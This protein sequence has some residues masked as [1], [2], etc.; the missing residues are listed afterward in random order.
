MSTIDKWVN[1]IEKELNLFT[2]EVGEKVSRVA[3]EVAKEGIEMLK[4][5]GDY[6]DRTGKYRKSFKYRIEK[7]NLGTSVKI[8]STQPQ[9]T[10][11]LEHGHAII[12]TS[13]QKYG[14]TWR[15]AISKSGAT[16]H[17]ARKGGT[18][19]TQAFPHWGPTEEFINKEFE[20]RIVQVLEE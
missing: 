9:L 17:H 12:N 8:Y 3:E 15:H 19:R 2:K 14:K 1:D 7:T 16:R 4:S 18:D 11:L 20:K 5:T 6:K 13:E 10:H